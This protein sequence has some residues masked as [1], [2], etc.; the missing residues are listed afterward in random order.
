[1]MAV[2][3]QR[4]LSINQGAGTKSMEKLS[5]GLRITKAADDAAGLTISEKM[6]SQVRG[7][8]QASKNSQDG[9]SLIQTAEGGLNET[10]SILQRMRELAVQSSTDTLQSTDR[11]ALNSEFKALG[12]EITDIANKTQFNKANVLDGT[13]TAKEFQTG[14]NS[15]D[16][17]S[18]TINAMDAT[19]LG[20][21]DS[22]ISIAGT[23]VSNATAAI[24]ALDSA[25]SSVS[26]ERAKLGAAQNR[27]EY[28]IKNLDTSSE[29]L[30]AAESRIRDVDMAKE[31]VNYTKNDILQ[32]AAQAM[33]SKAN[34]SPQSVLQL[35]R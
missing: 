6:R 27:L 31:M 32:Q 35:L 11:D 28:K 8:S 7:L 25:L 20:V 21:D 9:I 33:L 29:N 19:T 30:Q 22:A 4:Q 12:Y 13:F 18:L 26:T 1:M 17:L 23:T 15:G 16:S 14:A 5:S 2:N 3:A 34:Q 10:Q 24:T